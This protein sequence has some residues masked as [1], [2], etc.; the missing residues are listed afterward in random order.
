MA[1]S[2][3]IF[4]DTLK[5]TQTLKSVGVT[6]EVAEAMSDATNEALE[7]FSETRQLATRRDIQESEKKLQVFIVRCVTLPL[8]VIAALQTIFH[9][10]GNSV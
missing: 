1:A 9:F 4:F 2:K 3:H 7:G 8:G 6:Q 10:M 5:Y